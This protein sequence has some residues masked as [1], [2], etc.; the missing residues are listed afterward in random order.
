[1]RWKF[2]AGKSFRKV[3]KGGAGKFITLLCSL[4]FSFEHT[5]IQA[6][7]EIKLFVRHF[8]FHILYILLASKSIFCEHQEHV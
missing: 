5:Y 6:N 1:M 2:S 3:A 7:I 8:L 4:M